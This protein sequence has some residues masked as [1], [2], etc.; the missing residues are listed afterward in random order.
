M[1]IF[2]PSSVE[3]C[4]GG[5]NLCHYQLHKALLRKRRNVAMVVILSYLGLE[6]KTSSS[7]EDLP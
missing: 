2:V 6:R 4:E 7:L 5:H 3:T 1:G